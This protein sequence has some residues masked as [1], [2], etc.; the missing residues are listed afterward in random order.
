M[1]AESEARGSARGGAG[2]GGIG[3]L[4]MVNTE[5]L[6]KEPRLYHLLQ[7]PEAQAAPRLGGLRDEGR[8]WGGGREIVRYE[9]ASGI[10]TVP[11]HTTF[12]SERL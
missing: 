9:P 6:E 3:T 7:E 1:K 12:R 5:R 11:S 4:L 10:D 2:R 8:M